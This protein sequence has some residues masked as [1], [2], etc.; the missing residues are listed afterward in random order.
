MFPVW[1]DDDKCWCLSNSYV[2][3]SKNA[4]LS[5]VVRNHFMSVLFHADLS[6]FSPLLSG[7]H[8]YFCPRSPKCWVNHPLLYSWHDQLSLDS[9]EGTDRA[10]APGQA[11]YQ[12]DCACLWLPS[13]GPT[14]P[15]PW[16]VLYI[17]WSQ[18]DKIQVGPITWLNHSWLLRVDHSAQIYNPRFTFSSVTE[19]HEHWDW[20][21]IK[22][23]LV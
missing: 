13:L 14:D 20:T 2:K 9:G 17:H 3:S 11:Y 21:K 6:M 8:V 10:P 7:L 19:L 15:D 5:S 22:L 4:Y 16:I 1:V 18:D 12:E 23:G